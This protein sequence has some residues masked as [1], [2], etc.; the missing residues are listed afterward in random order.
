M[1]KIKILS[2]S[3]N[4]LCVMVFIEGKEEQAYQMSVD[5]STEYYTVIS[6]EIPEN[7]KM[8]ERQ[9]RIALLRYKGKSLP[10]EIETMWF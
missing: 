8:Y 10:D 9:A 5:I 1:M 4:V 2:L 3:G 6:S 7:H